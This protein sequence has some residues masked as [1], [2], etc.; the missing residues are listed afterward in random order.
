MAEETQIQKTG[1]FEVEP[2]S[3]SSMRVMCMSSLFA[4]F[5]VASLDLWGKVNHDYAFMYFLIFIIGAF[6]PKAIQSIPEHFGK[7]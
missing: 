7:K 6:A 2:G 4:S 5:I 3:T 1:M